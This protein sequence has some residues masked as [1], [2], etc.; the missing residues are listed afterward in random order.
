[1]SARLTLLTSVAG[2]HAT[3][4]LRQD[5][6]TGKIVKTDYGREKHFRVRIVEFTSFAHFCRCLDR[7]TQCPFDFVIRG[8]P[9]P[10]TDLQKA[11]RL[12][13]Q[14]PETGE[15][16]TFT[17][18]PRSWF[19]ADLDKIPKPVAIDPVTDP[20]GA[21]EYLIGL[22]PPELHD[23]SCW[24]QFTCSQ[25]LPGHEETLSARL[26][27]CLLE[28]LD[29]AALTRWARAAN[30]AAGTKLLDDA[31][32]R[33]VQPHYVAAPIFDNLP[34]PLPRR[35]GVRVGLDETVSLVI[36]EPVNDDPYVAG[37]GYV[38]LGVNG[39][40]AEIGSERGFRAPMVSA[41]AAYYAANGP[42]ADAELIKAR[43]REA[44]DTALPNGRSEA[45]LN[46]YRS[47]RHLGDIIAWVRAR[48]RMNPRRDGPAAPEC[49]PTNG[50]HTVGVSLDDFYAYM[51]MHKYIFAPTRELWPAESVNS[52]IPHVPVLDNAG[53]PVLGPDGNPK[54]IRASLWLDQNRA[55]EQMTWCPG[56]PMIMTDKL[57][58]DGGWIDRKGVRTFNLYRPPIHRR[59]DPTKVQLWLD[60]VHWVFPDDAEHIIKWLSQRVQQPQQKINHALV[61]GG[62]QGIGKDTILEP[63]KHAVG[64]WNFSEPPPQQV[65]GRFNGYIKAVIMRINEARDLGE[66]DRF[67]FY[68]HMKAYIA[69]PPDVL[70]CDEKNIREHAV[71]NVCGV[72]ITTNHKTDGIYLPADDR[73]HYVAWSDRKKEVLPDS[74][75]NELYGWYDAG[76]DANVSAYLSGLSLSG[77]DPKTP[78]PKTPAF[79]EIVNA[80]RPPEDAELADVLDD[81]GNPQAVT[82]Q[83]LSNRAPTA[84]A[85]Y[86]RDRRNSRVIPHRLEECGYV[87]V[88]NKH[89][90]DGQWKVNGKRQAVYARADLPLNE[91]YSAAA[92]KQSG[93]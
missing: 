14:D 2:L 3:K 50:G 22:L 60:H 74:Y 37:D 81:L 61:L 33:A 7:L 11:R 91:R 79:W 57:V 27:F 66:H 40:L 80:S 82:L 30:R 6:K 69:A 17:E 58:S 5:R 78:P 83:Q 13:H 56:L 32:Y 87:R 89:A 38:G 18:A 49:Q 65:M 20:D 10:G 9:L 73:R 90:K 46:R 42:D 63:V 41:V 92:E 88:E 48:E 4:R 84:F 35:H 24:W 15:S 36:P 53:N 23:A 71:F 93:R 75:W 12:V 54:T 16:A 86:L 34:D 52:R 55:V 28:P 21:I 8:E 25:N 85:D 62:N 45:D 31:L 43:V 47:D 1:L 51:P 70:R 72:I 29:D 19:A 64:P 39:H 77:F 68:D 59:G 76:G 44:I 26:W 67:K